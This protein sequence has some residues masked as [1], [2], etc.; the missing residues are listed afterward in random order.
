MGTPAYPQNFPVRNR[1]IS[2]MSAGVVIV[3]GGEYSGSA[4]TARLAMEQNRDVFAVPGNITSKMSWGP[5]MLIKQ[6]AKLVQEWNDVVVEL[7]AA[8]RRWLSDRFRKQ[9]TINDI[10]TAESST[11]AAASLSPVSRTVLQALKPDLAVSLDQLIETVDGTS[12]SEVIA[13]LFELE[14]MGLVR[15]IPGKSFLRVW[16]A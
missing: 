15:Q 13:T 11:P 5:N 1:I 16:G 9:L 12:P 7:P 14:L 2:G 8:D 6:G 4:I 10:Q 3:E